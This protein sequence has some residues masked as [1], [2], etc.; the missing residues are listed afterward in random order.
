MKANPQYTEKTAT[1]SEISSAGG[2]DP[3]TRMTTQKLQEAG[4]RGNRLTGVKYE[5]WNMW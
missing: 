1:F 4:P 3:Y 5:I 2:G